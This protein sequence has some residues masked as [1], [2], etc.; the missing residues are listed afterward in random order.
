MANKKLITCDF[1]ERKFSS[2]EAYNAHNV[3]CKRLRDIYRHVLGRTQNGQLLLVDILTDTGFFDEEP[4]ATSEQIALA[5]YGKK[6]LRKCGVWNKKN[7]MNIVRA[8][9]G[10]GKTKADRL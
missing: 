8:L 1:C 3:L 7:R 2:E 5:N 9:F 4:A 10:P 6:L